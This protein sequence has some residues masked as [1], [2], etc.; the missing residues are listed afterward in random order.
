VEALRPP[1]C[2]PDPSDQVSSLHLLYFTLGMDAHTPIAIGY[3]DPHTVQL[4]TR[5]PVR[6]SL[7]TLGLECFRGIGEGVNPQ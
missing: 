2:R 4:G 3:V 6:P 1:H 5:I 7:D